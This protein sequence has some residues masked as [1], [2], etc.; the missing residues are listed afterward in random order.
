MAESS[1][2]NGIPKTRSIMH[3]GLFVLVLLGYF[4]SEAF[5]RRLIYNT[6]SEKR[7]GTETDKLIS[8]L[9]EFLQSYLKAYAKRLEIQDKLKV[10]TDSSERVKLLFELSA[11]SGGETVS[12]SL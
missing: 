1:E 2:K 7:S 5:M 6:P 11:Q 3:Y 10:T 12:Q 4:S 8:S 9:P